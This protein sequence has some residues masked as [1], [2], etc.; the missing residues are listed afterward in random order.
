[1]FPTVIFRGNYSGHLQRPSY[2]MESKMEMRVGA[3]L[4][5]L[6]SLLMCGCERKQAGCATRLEIR[7]DNLTR[8]TQRHLKEV[9]TREFVWNHWRERKCATLLLESVSKEGKETDSDFEIKP[10]PAGRLAMVVTIKRARY[11]YQGQVF[12]HENDKYDVYTIERVKP[13]NP[14]LLN[15]NSK[16]EVLPENANLSGFD[17]CLRFKGLGNEVVSFF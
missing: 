12:W 17:Y 13:N 9:E 5:L 7:L 8:I 1:M 10:L 16:V 6:L 3:V 15:V 11:G 2:L 14:D 4:I